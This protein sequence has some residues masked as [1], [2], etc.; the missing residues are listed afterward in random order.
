MRELARAAL[1]LALTALVFEGFMVAAILVKLD[2]ARLFQE[3]WRTLREPAVRHWSD[4]TA[5]IA[6]TWLA[7]SGL[8]SLAQLAPALREPRRRV[9]KIVSAMVVISLL[10]TVPIFTVITV[11][12]ARVSQIL[13][14]PRPGGGGGRDLRGAG[15]PGADVADRGRLPAGRRQR[16]VHRLLQR[17]Q[18]GRR[19]RLPAGHAGH[20]EQ[21]LW[22]AA[23]GGGGHHR[24]VGG[25]GDRHRGPDAGAGEDLR[26]RPARLLR[27]HVG[28]PDGPGLARAAG[29]DAPAGPRH[30]QRGA[31]L[32]L[33]DQPLHQAQVDAL[34]GARHR[35]PA[36]RRVRH[37]PRLDPLGALRLPARRLGRAG[38]VGGAVGQRGG[39]AGG[40]G[41]A[42]GDVPVDDPG[43]AARP[44][45]EPVPRGGAPRARGRGRGRLRHL[46]RR[47]AGALL[48]APHRPLGR[49]AGDASTPRSPT[50]GRRGLEAVPIGGWRTTPARRSPRRR[51]RWGS[52]A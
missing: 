52:A 37:P 13:P 25:A 29:R 28:E 39:D 42:P 51:R 20:P 12:A 2:V 48:P 50:C 1:V 21:A 22:N 23:R 18:G 30:R 17:V 8:E 27:D 15:A 26:L 33:G 32:P 43:R 49:G 19:A 46:R 40:G 3:V 14:Q 9:T 34:R 41:R 5:G 7:F 6:A 11:E 45:R 4:A 10:V 44:Q 38:R 16:R 36:G 35:V 24:G 31:A 47:G